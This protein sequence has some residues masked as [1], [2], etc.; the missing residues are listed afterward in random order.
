MH[1]VQM[2]GHFLSDKKH[3]GSK[4][5]D[6]NKNTTLGSCSANLAPA[7]L[8]LSLSLPVCIFLALFHVF[9]IILHVFFMYS[10][11]LCFD[12]F[13]FDS[14]AILIKSPSLFCTSTTFQRPSAPAEL[15]A[16]DAFGASP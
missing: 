11:S 16:P 10:S 1:L 6:I 5:A 8:S 4:W 14:Q 3:G 2:E 7:D 15:Q 9:F 12:F 13:D